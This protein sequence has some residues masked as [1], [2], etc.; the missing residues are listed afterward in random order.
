[1]IKVLAKA[2]AVYEEVA[3]KSTVRPVR[4]FEIAEACQI[5]P[6]MVMR[7]LQTLV[8]LKYL[9][10]VSR[11]AGYTIGPKAHSLELCF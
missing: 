3:R 6:A 9:R 11:Q 2:F 8:R 7:L 4:C 1:M 5:A 10:Q